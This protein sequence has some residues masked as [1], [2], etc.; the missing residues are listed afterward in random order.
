MAVLAVLVLVHELGH[1]WV[2]R[3]NGVIAEEFGFGFPPRLVGFFKDKEGKRRW[4]F[5]SKEI[6]KEIKNR[7]ETIYSINLIPLGGFV[8]I[9]GEEGEG[10]DD[11]KSFSSKGV[12]T[13]FRI[14][15]AGV[16]MNVVLAMILFAGAF[17]LGIPQ[18]VSE[19]SEGSL[20]GQVQ[21]LEVKKGSA[22]EEAGLKMGDQILSLVVQGE[23]KEVTMIKD[24]QEFI[25]EKAGQEV[26]IRVKS[27]TNEQIHDLK[28]RVPVNDPEGDG[29]LGIAM[30]KT[31]IKKY[32]LLQSIWIGAISALSSIGMIVFFLINLLIKIIRFEP[33]SVD[34]AGPVGIAVL[35]K[36]TAELGLAYLFQF[37]AFLSV[38]LAVINFLPFPALD[39]GRALF[40]AIEKI[41]GKPIGQKIENTTHAIGFILLLVLMIFVTIRDF[42]NF[43]IVGKIKNLF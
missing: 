43:E 27:P 7:E 4:I 11:P 8:K 40:L 3:R 18:L 33:V 26:T 39:G 41:K 20:D 22:A 10:K 23:V 2:A 31:I 13:R 30:G 25:K 17:Y 36:Q 38:N 29:L 14:I 37:A 35:T 32:T 9:Y 12:F 21:I 15:A 42:V 1:F 5:G 16:A 28:V 19:E 34:L 24:V 6:E